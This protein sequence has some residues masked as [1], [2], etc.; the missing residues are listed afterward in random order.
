[1]QY[2]DDDNGADQNRDYARASDPALHSEEW[3]N[4]KITMTASAPT[5]L[6]MS[7]RN[8]SHSNR[9]AFDR[10]AMLLASSSAS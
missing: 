3:H 5:V 2:S 4:Q 7:R 6:R 1:M 9:A 10:T 8:I